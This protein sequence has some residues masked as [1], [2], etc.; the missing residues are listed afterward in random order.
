MHET[1]D[2]MNFRYGNISALVSAAHSDV[3]QVVKQFFFSTQNTTTNKLVKKEN[4][5]IN[6]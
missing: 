5:Q 2:V 3:E 1:A 4:K 6:K